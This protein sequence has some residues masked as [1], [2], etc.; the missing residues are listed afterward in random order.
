M[1][2]EDHLADQRGREKCGAIGKPGGDGEASEE[3]KDGD[4]AELLPF[5]CGSGKQKEQ[6]E[7]VEDEIFSE[8]V[9]IVE[10]IRVTTDDEGEAA[11][12]NNAFLPVGPGGFAQNQKQTEAHG[13]DLKDG[14][15]L[16]DDQPVTEEAHPGVGDQDEEGLQSDVE[17]CV[18]VGAAMEG[19]GVPEPHCFTPHLGVEDHRQAK[20][21]A[22]HDGRHLKD[23]GA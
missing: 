23:R 6:Q 12:Q 8:H 9:V 4:E 1:T 13:A 18:E 21:E 20:E 22:K 3:A 10:A 16:S 5:G 19:H 2:E 15:D 14:R 7:R 17:I 11:E